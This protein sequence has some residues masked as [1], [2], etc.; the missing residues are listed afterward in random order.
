MSGTPSS[1]IATW[2]DSDPRTEISAIPLE[3]LR[4]RMNGILRSASSIDA[5]GGMGSAEGKVTMPATPPDVVAWRMPFTVTPSTVN[6]VSGAK[7]SGRTCAESDSGIA[8]PTAARTS[9]I[10]IRARTRGRCT[11]C[12]IYSDSQILCVL[13]CRKGTQRLGANQII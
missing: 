5:A 1:K 2:R 13:G 4:T 7:V 12:L 9:A 6:T 11:L 8:L 3:F 10:L